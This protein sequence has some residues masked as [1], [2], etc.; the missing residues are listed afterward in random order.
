VWVRGAVAAAWAVVVGV[1]AL[2][3]LALIIWAADSASTASA[4]GAMQFA[5][6]LWLLAHRVPLR[7][8]SAGA[9]T[10]PPMA[11]TLIIGALVARGAAILARSA[12]CQDVRDIGVIATAVTA[13]Y[14]VMATVLAVLTPSAALRP[15]VAAAFLS[16]IVIAAIAS[17]I[18]AARGSGLAGPTWRAMPAETQGVLAGIGRAAVVMFG[19]A[20]VLSVGSLLAH[21]HEFG[22]IAG[23]YNGGP[24]MIAMAALSILMV[25]NAVCF[26]VGY[27]SGPGFAIGTGTSVT[28]TSVHLGAVPAFP[29]LA[30][31]PSGP[32][33]WQLM[34]LFI[35]AVVGAGV[36]AGL[37]LAA[38]PSIGLRTQLQ[39]AAVVG[40]VFGVA[41]AAVTGFAGGPS[42][43][44]RLSS[45]G[46]SPWRVGFATAIEIAVIAMAVVALVHY[47]RRLREAT[48][49]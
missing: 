25:P 28:Y 40:A 1:A 14:A 29:L 34:A 23:D 46:P 10:I 21:V 5:V 41:V 27:I 31:V 42:G 6:Q 30:A 37:R 3:V 12:D 11:L 32:A 17:S 2:I 48:D 9:L 45:V 7:I 39:L 49:R 13:P 36:A 22:S 38:V 43:P 15:S 24:G 19:A 33:P 44:G 16:S 4:G 20:T 47:V 8:P 18:G 35:A 26:A